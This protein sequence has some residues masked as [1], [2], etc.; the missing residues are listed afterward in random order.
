MHYSRNKKRITFKDD[1]LYRQYYNE[2][3]NL[4]QQQVIL[5]VQL[6]AILLKSLHGTASKHPG[7]FQM[8]QQND[9]NTTFQQLPKRTSMGKT[10]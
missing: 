9:A 2:V 10:T 5:R 7:I 1:I 4:S 8:M 3:G 6:L